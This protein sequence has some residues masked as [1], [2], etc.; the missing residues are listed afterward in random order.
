MI[1][2]DVERTR[3]RSGWPVRRTLQ[4]LGLPAATF[5]RQRAALAA[6]SPLSRPPRP[7]SIHE[8][9][10]AERAAVTAFARKHPELRH[11]ALAWTMVDEDVAYL[12]SSTVYR[13][14]AAA[15]LVERWTPKV[16]GRGALR[17]R[18]SGPGQQWQ[19]D[20]RYIKVA[21]RTYYLI[22]FL[23][24]FSRFIVYHELLRWMDGETVSL[25]AQGALETVSAA[26]REAIRIQSDNGSAFVSA[27][28]ARVL[29]ESG[30]GHHRIYPH[31]PEQNGFVERVL[32]TLGEPLY[33]D[34]LVSFEQAA[35]AIEYIVHWY[36]HQRLHSA[37]G[38]VTP[39]AA[40]RGEAD[41]TREERRL[42]LTAARHAR[43]EENLRLRQ[44]SMLITGSLASGKPQSL[45]TRVSQIA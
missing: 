20:L 27:D 33:E 19:T 31:T 22:V 10:A 29:R 23:D 26:E 41:R 1:V 6:V 37:L 30:V 11:R 16:R 25:A 35:H 42:K 36:N 21:G 15:G 34:E 17:A 18:P 45:N 32:R 5:Y 13:I 2:A 14:L 7:V 4:A 24:V 28:F 38:Y 8:A 9:T 44:R 39:A 40:H 12:S 3:T 43:K